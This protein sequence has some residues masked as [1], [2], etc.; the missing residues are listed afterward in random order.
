M[1]TAV[2]APL[3]YQGHR[4]CVAVSWRLVEL[5]T[6]PEWQCICSSY[7]KDIRGVLAQNIRSNVHIFI[8]LS[9][10]RT[11]MLEQ[12][13]FLTTEHSLYMQLES[14]SHNFV[15]HQIPNIAYQ[16]KVEWKYKF[17]CHFYTWPAILIEAHFLSSYRSDW[18][19]AQVTLFLACSTSGPVW[20]QVDALELKNYSN[21]AAVR[22]LTFIWF[23]ACDQWL[24]FIKGD[25]RTDRLSI[26]YSHCSS[27]II[28]RVDFV[29][30]VWPIF[31]LVFPVRISVVTTRH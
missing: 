8:H 9:C 31:V 14:L 16:A 23:Q 12:S 27:P 28:K 22:C 5:T 10:Y 1:G 30:I 3:P 19:L 29:I 15:F 6:D 20:L 2:S 21:T 13:Y 18:P 4:W 7:C 25:I 17:A 11:H 24:F 26:D